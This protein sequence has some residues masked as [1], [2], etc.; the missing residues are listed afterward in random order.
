MPTLANKRVLLGVTGGIAAYKS[1]DLVRRLREAGADVRVAMTRAAGEF[2]TPLTLQAVS[3]HPVH[4]ALLDTEAEAGMSH[5]ELARWADAVLVAP[6]SADFIA[7]LVLGRADDLLSALCLATAAPLA[8]APAMNQQMWQNPATQSNLARLRERGVR[9]FGPASGSQACGEVGPGRMLEPAELVG[10]AA[11]IFATGELDG[12]RVLVTGGP[13]WEAIDPVRGLTNRSSGK[14]GYAVAAA[15]AEAGARAVLVSGP[16]TLPDP[17][18]VRTVRVVSAREMHDAVMAEIDAADIFVGVAAV[19]DYRPVES[20]PRKIKK[21]A[22]R[23]TL[24]LVR[25]PDILADVAKRRPDIYA[26]GFAAETEDLEARARA[27]LEAKGLDLVAANLV[28]RPGSGFEADTNTL[29]LVDRRGT[30][31]LAQAH[32]TALARILIHE[33]AQRYHAQG[34]AQDSRHAHRH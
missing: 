22:E 30:T 11:E 31:E 12:V 23:L 10:L 29:L 9:V 20:A 6:A 5:I 26:V 21:E 19:A 2:I 34:R 17:D 33:I 14:M 13:T 8:V 32:K 3:G 7:R 18:R 1:A 15:A 27:K 16:T 25:N 28:G 4:Q 24:D